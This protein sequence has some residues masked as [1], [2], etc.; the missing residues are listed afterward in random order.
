MISLIAVAM[1]STIPDW[2]SDDMFVIFSLWL[3]FTAFIKST[4]ILI[5]ILSV[6]LSKKQTPGRFQKINNPSGNPPEL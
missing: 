4:E 2:P 1:A 5:P 3:F 6:H